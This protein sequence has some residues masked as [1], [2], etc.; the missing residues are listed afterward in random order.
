MNFNLF[1]QQGSK[2]YLVEKRGFKNFKLGDPVENY[3][4][5]VREFADEGDGLKQY[6]VIDPKLLKIGNDIKLTSILIAAYNGF[7]MS[8]VLIV[9]DNDDIKQ[10]ILATLINA[11]GNPDK[12]ESQIEK[13]PDLESQLNEAWKRIRLIGKNDHKWETKNK[14]VVLTYKEKNYLSLVTFIDTKIMMRYNKSLS[15]NAK[16]ASK[17]FIG[18]PDYLLIK[19]GFNIF[20]LGTS[21]KN[22][23]KYIEYV[24]DEEKGAKMYKVVDQNIL[25][26]SYD[27]QI[28]SILISTYGDNI[29]GISVFVKKRDK[30]KLLVKLFTFY[31]LT[32][33]VNQFFGNY[34][35]Y[36]KDGDI[37]VVFKTVGKEEQ[38]CLAQFMDVSIIQKQKADLKRAKEQSNLNDI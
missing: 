26:N 33:D 31:G 24:S 29:M 25:N 28:S 27:M 22:Y 1:A 12:K 34:K 21:I 14:E 6:E 30:A 9:P 10:Q 38:E 13:K 32:D 2:E 17:T 11:Y 3:K 5:Y 37:A 8:I 23:S 4:D 16:I 15:S 35:W 18:N 7:I 20:R 19:S 36:S